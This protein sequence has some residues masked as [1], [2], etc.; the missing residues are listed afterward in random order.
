[1]AGS[2]N[3]L[4]G[5]QVGITLPTLGELTHHGLGTGS[6]SKDIAAAARHVEQLGFESVWVPDLIIGDG[7]A[8]LE[9]TATVATA[10]AVTERVLVGFGVYILPLRPVAWTAAQIQTLQHLSG[11]RVVLGVG[12]G[13]FPGSPFWRAVD[14]PS[15]DRFRR[16][17]EALDLLPRLIAGEPTSGGNGDGPVVTLAPAASV[18]PIL[19]GG[20]SDG[21][22][23]R[24]AR[25]DIG[26]F[27]SL[28]TAADVRAGLSTLRE[29]RAQRGGPAPSVAVGGHAMIG[30]A[31]EVRLTRETF[32]RGLVDTHRMP[33][34]QAKAVPLYGSLHAVTERLASY[35]E[36]GAQR[37]VLALD[38]QDWMRQAE[39]LAT[40]RS[41]L[42]G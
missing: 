39:L 29:L 41:A 21:A 3:P 19:F 2:T 7:T 25:R 26:W 4:G 8:A 22:I 27:P 35:A 12:A 16:T 17:D 13:G 11:N 30:T 42:A 23:R 6:L 33:T 34:E 40:A 37:V 28:R 1:M 9:A 15:R 10:A 32:V 31:A 20:N 38:G 5:L 18:P 14:G 36:V 24:V